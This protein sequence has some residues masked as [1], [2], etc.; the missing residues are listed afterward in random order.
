MIW[1]FLKSI[2]IK[3][4]VVEFRCKYCKDI[5]CPV[6]NMGLHYPCKYYVE[7]GGYKM[8]K[9]K[10]VINVLKKILFYVLAIAMGLS[11]SFCLLL[12][13]IRPWLEELLS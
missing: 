4:Y 10:L 6:R 3:L 1:Q 9:G 8:K 2:T 7:V 12:P 5:A 13:F 11:I